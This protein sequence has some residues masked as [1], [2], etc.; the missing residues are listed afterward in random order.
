V[1]RLVEQS[2][3]LPHR[4]GRLRRLLRERG[5]ACGGLSIPAV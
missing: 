5:A 2:R 4:A 3:P 1:H